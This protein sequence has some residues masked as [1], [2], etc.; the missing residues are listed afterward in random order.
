MIG[1]KDRGILQIF[2]TPSPY[3]HEITEYIQRFQGFTGFFDKGNVGDLMK[4]TKDFSK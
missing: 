1:S 3:N 2:T 4:S